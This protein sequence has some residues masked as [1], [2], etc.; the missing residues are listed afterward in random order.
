MAIKQG[1]KSSGSHKIK[2]KTFDKQ[3]MYQ[4]NYVCVISKV[5]NCYDFLWFWR[6]FCNG[7]YHIIIK[8]YFFLLSTDWCMSYFNFLSPIYI[9]V[10]NGYIKLILTINNRRWFRFQT[11]KV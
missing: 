7:P 3:N 11:R 9:K 8:N 6:I 2:R 1:S 10:T 5:F 4:L